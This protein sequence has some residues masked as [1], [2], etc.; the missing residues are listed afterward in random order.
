ALKDLGIL[1]AVD[2]F[3]SGYS[4]LNHLKRLP[5]DSVKID[6]SF[7]EG[8]GRNPVD[9]GIVRAVVDVARTLNLTLTAEGIETPEQ[10]AQLRPRHRMRPGGSIEGGP[11]GPPRIYSAWMIPASSGGS[12]LPP[13]ST[14]PT[15]APFSTGSFPEST[16]AAATAPVGSASSFARKSRKRTARTISAS[17]TS[18]TSARRA[19]RTGN[20]SSPGMR[21]L[22]PSAIVDRSE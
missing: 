6:R 10:L 7:V 9:T 22:M 11:R 2:D 4:S 21:T 17:L 8:I 20:V 13:D 18:N 15:R 1:L 3:G 19:F 12:T 14:T 5:I 16:A